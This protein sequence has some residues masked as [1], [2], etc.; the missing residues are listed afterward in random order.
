MESDARYTLVGAVLLAVVVAAA[1]ATVWL[2]RTGGGVE[3]RY[4]M[5]HFDHQPLTGLQSGADFSKPSRLILSR[6]PFV[7]IMSKGM[8]SLSAIF[9]MS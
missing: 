1:L 6:E 2:A 8:P 4:Y 9:L 3:F 7:W 5:I